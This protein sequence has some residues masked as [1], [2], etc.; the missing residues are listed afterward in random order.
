MKNVL[1]AI[2]S[3]AASP[4]FAHSGM[5]MHPHPDDPSWLPILIIGFGIAGAATVAWMRSK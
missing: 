3:V 2:A 4:A 5:H 1:I